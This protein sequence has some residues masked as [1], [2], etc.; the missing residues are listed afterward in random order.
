MTV[1]QYYKQSGIVLLEALTVFIPVIIAMIV[2]FFV[3]SYLLRLNRLRTWM[4]KEIEH[5]PSKFSLVHTGDQDFY[6]YNRM[7]GNDLWGFQQDLDGLAEKME[8]DFE[9][10]GICHEQSC[11]YALAFAVVSYGIDM[12]DGQRIDLYTAPK[13]CGVGSSGRACRNYFRQVGNLSQD[14]GIYRNAQDVFEKLTGPRQLNL[15]STFALPSSLYG[16]QAAQEYGSYRVVSNPDEPFGRDFI[17]SAVVYAV[18]AVVDMSETPEGRVMC[19]F[20]HGTK[21][22]FRSP[23]RQDLRHLNVRMLV[24]SPKKVL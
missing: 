7:R 13:D 3:A 17:R 8:K 23:L 11:R 21:D 6:L 18:R 16:S 22:C 14:D 1:K 10:L 19:F 15:A 4:E 9:A 20:K 5:V 24:G 2:L 12:R